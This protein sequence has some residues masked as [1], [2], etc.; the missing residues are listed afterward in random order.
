[1]QLDL[2]LST[3]DSVSAY[4]NG[5]TKWMNVITGDTGFNWNNPEAYISAGDTCPAGYP[6]TIDDIYI[7]GRDECIDGPYNV[8]GSAGPRWSYNGKTLSGKMRF[9][10]EDVIRYSAAD[11]EG[12]VLHEMGHVFGIGT[13]WGAFVNQTLSHYTGTNG[14][15]VWQ[16]DWGCSGN[17]P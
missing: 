7:C 3:A 11:W 15:N 16:N 17:P 12:V 5:R 8:L 4:L 13:T 9:D 2:D 1:M 14:V 10:K 6:S